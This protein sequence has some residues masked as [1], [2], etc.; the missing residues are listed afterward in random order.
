MER[1]ICDEL[2]LPLI[3]AASFF[4]L[5]GYHSPLVSPRLTALPL[6]TRLFLTPA[7]LSFRTFST[8]HRRSAYPHVSIYIHIQTQRAYKRSYTPLLLSPWFLISP[9]IA[10]LARLGQDPGSEA[11]PDWKRVRVR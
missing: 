11:R 6:F 10:A 3:T 4:A 7:F 5:R 1:V 9:L 2:A 8:P